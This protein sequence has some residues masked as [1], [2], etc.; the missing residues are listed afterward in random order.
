MISR[1]DAK[2]L[3]KTPKPKPVKSKKKKAQKGKK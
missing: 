2:P 1:T 3:M